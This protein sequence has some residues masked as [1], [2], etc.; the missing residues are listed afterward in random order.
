MGPRL[1]ICEPC[2][3]DPP[4]VVGFLKKLKVNLAEVSF[5]A[6]RF[7]KIAITVARFS[8]LTVSTSTK[9]CGRFFW[10]TP[11]RVD[12]D[13]PG[14]QPGLDLTLKYLKLIRDLNFFLLY[15]QTYVNGMNKASKLLRFLS[16]SLSLFAFTGWNGIGPNFFSS[17]F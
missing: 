8:K 5:Q 12:G 16:L 11:F 3:G 7:L 6:F 2:H 1:V 15:L 17:K 13:S 4:R 14:L 9:A 10:K